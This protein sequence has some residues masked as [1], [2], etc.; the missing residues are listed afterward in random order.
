MPITSTKEDLLP[1]IKY[2]IEPPAN[3]AP[4]QAMEMAPPA[5]S[6][7]AKVSS[8]GGSITLIGAFGCSLVLHYIISGSGIDLTLQ[9]RTPVGSKTLGHAVL[10]AQHPTIT[11]GGSISSFKAQVKL[12]FDV[13]K[14]NLSAEAT[15]CVP[16]LG[17]KRGHVQ[18]H[19]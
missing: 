12:S 4:S 17:C 9:L 3:F 16:F 5:D 8:T 18:V 2:E 15:I 7:A 6:L 14:L 13:H 1:D 19:I 10:N 11:L